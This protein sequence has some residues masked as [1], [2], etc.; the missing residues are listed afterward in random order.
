MVLKDE[1]QEHSQEYMSIS[2][3]SLS[4]LTLVIEQPSL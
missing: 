3:R 2:A 1:Q 4:V